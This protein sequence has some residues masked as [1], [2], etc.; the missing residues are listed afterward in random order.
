[1]RRMR[2]LGSA[3]GLVVLGSACATSTGGNGAAAFSATPS[4]Q[5]LS[6]QEQVAW[7]DSV[8]AQALADV[9]GPGASIR[10]EFSNLAGSRRVRASFNLEADAYVVIGHIDA[11]G[12]LRIAFPNDPSQD[13][14]FVK[15]NKTY[16]TQ[17]FF[18]G[19]TAEYRARAYDARLVTRNPDAYDGGLGYMFI[20]A[21]WRPMHFDRFRQGDNWDTFEL[22]DDS[23]LRDPRPAIYELATLLVGENRE[24]YTVKFARYYNSTNIYG[25]MAYG[26]SA[27]SSFN[28]CAGY[29][30]LGFAYDPLADGFMDLYMLSAYG[31]NGYGY[32]GMSFSR[33]GVNYYYD[34]FSGCYRSSNGGLG[35]YT[36]GYRIA[37][38]PTNPGNGGVP[39]VKRPFDPEGFRVPLNPR[40]VQPSSLPVGR[41]VETNASGELPAASPSY[42]QRGLI[43]SD[44]P[45]G[46]L[47]GRREPRVATR[48]AQERARPSIQ[49]MVGR[50][51]TTN[52]GSSR[53]SS[54]NGYRNS[55]GSSTYDRPV[56]R[57][58]GTSSSGSGY[59]SGRSAAPSS[60]GGSVG[61]TSSGTGSSSAAA[62]PPA[63]TGSGPTGSSTGSRPPF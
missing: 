24:A 1:M 8:Y 55:S 49:D 27:Y 2:V 44:D 19:F 56:A 4:I 17:E 31:S 52:E 22:T 40:P 32:G 13:D 48:E 26:Q 45:N 25:G 28:Y 34:S 15:G 10:A 11:S 61:A 42:R 18:A 58:R 38:G 50:R 33:R 54:N 36:P 46:G 47:P 7:R 39:T 37:Q 59:D 63:S 41:G 16:R 5:K 62:P 43:T 35:R 29:R 60:T 9:E 57:D 12:V 51:P 30:P 21:S 20:I 14:G 53:A 23:Y 3:L 6:R